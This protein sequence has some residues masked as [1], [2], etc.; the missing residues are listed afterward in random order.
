M[1]L[2]ELTG[3]FLELQDMMDEADPDVI[4]DTME[5]IEGDFDEKIENY[6]KVIRNQQAKLEAIDAEVKR[7]RE[8]ARIVT[9]NIDRMKATMMEAMKATGRTKV[10]GELFK[11][12]VRKNGGKLPVVVDVDVL[13]LPPEL[14]RYDVKPDTDAIRAYLDTGVISPWCH[15]GERGESVVIK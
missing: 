7:L 15:Y 1:T 5:A 4:R 3:A 6:A 13:E 11:V 10:D 9:A 14:V 8:R 12:A 2:Y